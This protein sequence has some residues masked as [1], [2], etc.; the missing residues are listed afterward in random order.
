[1]VEGVVDRSAV[2]DQPEGLGA[3]DQRADGRRGGLLR[4]V[5]ERTRLGHETLHQRVEQYPGLG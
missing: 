5:A 2:Q 1:M 3:V 4:G